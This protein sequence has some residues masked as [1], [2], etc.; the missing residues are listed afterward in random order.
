MASG[1][2]HASF[3]HRSQSDN[4]VIIEL[5]PLSALG[6]LRPGLVLW[7][8]SRTVTFLC[9]AVAHQLGLA[10][11]CSPLLSEGCRHWG[12]EAAFAGLLSQALP[13]QGQS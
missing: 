7:L 11:R 10:G 8:G 4:G 13:L 3:R 9:E 12:L 6:C 5:T 2:K 1:R